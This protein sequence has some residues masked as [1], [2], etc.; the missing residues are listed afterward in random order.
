[1]DRSDVPWMQYLVQSV[2]VF[3]AV[4][5][6]QYLF[7]GT[8]TMVVALVVAIGFFAM[9]VVVDQYTDR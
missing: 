8:T 3:G 5:A 6:F 7:R 9:S 2:V 1:M 4:L